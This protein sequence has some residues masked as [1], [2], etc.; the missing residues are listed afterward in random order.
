MRCLPQDNGDYNW[1]IRIHTFRL[2]AV[3]LYI[4]QQETGRVLRAVVDIL[5]C[6]CERV[7]PTTGW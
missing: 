5:K 3:G 7:D 6:M 4:E 1:C 2:Q